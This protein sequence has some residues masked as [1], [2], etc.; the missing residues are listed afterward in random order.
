MSKLEGVKN[1]NGSPKKPGTS[2]FAIF[3]IYKFSDLQIH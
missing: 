3:L 1:W 2:A